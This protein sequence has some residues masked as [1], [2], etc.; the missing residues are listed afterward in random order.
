VVI[1]SVPEGDDKPYKYPGIFT[2]VDA[3][4][5]NKVDLLPHLEYDVP[6]FCDVVRGLNP[7]A[8]IF[9]ISCKKGEGIDE[10][11]GWLTGML[12]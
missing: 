6:V 3:V 7:R 10:W 1:T 4:V 9:Q 8:R 11:T 12:T 2:V 5:I